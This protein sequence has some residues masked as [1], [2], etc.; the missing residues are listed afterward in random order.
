MCWVSSKVITRIISLGSSLLGAITLAIYIYS[1]TEHPLKFRW[2][3]G[4]VALLSKPAISLKR[5]KTGPRF[6]LMTNRK[7]HTRFRLMPCRNQRPWMTLKSH[8][9]L[10]FK[11]HFNIL[12]IL[13]INVPMTPDSDNIRFMRIFAGV[14]WRG[15]SNNGGTI[16]NVHF[17]AF[18][19]Y[20]FRLRHLKNWGQHVI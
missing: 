10:C 20:V 6:L 18:G 17:R 15:A 11:T 16:E 9:A 12:F 19:H 4:W 13:T 5:D 3:R 8:Y 1:P 2:N 14:P 7:S